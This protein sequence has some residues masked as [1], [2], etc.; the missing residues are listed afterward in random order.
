MNC[1]FGFPDVVACPPDRACAPVHGPGNAGSGFIS[2]GAPGFD[3]SIVQNCNGTPGGEPFQPQMTLTASGGSLPVDRASAQLAITLATGTVV[4][5]C[6]GSDPAYGPDGQF[7]T[8][9]D[10][11]SARGIPS[12]VLFT[13]SSASATA[14]NPGDFDGDLLGPIETSGAPFICDN[15]TIGVAA[16]DLAGAFTACDQG[17]DG[18]ATLNLVCE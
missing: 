10:S 14:L 3:L 5:G 4:G 18:A 2:C 9:D 15:G 17:S 16:L 12:S 8:A 7:C 6:A 13:T 11:V 1:S